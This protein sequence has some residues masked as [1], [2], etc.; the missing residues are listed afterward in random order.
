MQASPRLA[1]MDGQVAENGWRIVMLTRLVPIFPFNLQN[2]AY[3]ITR[4]GFWPYL[5]TSSIC[6]VPGSAALTFA[7][8]ALSDGRGDIKRTLAYL[9]DRGR[10]PGAHLADPALDPAPEQAGGRSLEGRGHRGPCG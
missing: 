1:K 8:G 2:Y 4:I 5:I 9:G 7:G 3:G 6:I 10:A